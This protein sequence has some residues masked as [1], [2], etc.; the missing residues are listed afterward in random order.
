MCLNLSWHGFWTDFSARKAAKMESLAW[1]HQDIAA[2]SRPLRNSLIA[3]TR[4]TLWAEGG[5]GQSQGISKTRRMLTDT[6]TLL[7]ELKPLAQLQYFSGLP[8][9]GEGHPLHVQSHVV[10]AERGST[11]PLGKTAYNTTSPAVSL[12]CPGWGTH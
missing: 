4:H 1:R 9:R 8:G 10:P 3:S 6:L 11:Q 5:R 12:T 7:P 2:P